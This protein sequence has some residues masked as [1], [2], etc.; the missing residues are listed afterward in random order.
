[1][2]GKNT[3]ARDDEMGHL[4]EELRALHVELAE[5]RKM[6]D[7]LHRQRMEM[8]VRQVAR[9]APVQPSR[10]SRTAQR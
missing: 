1:M 5:F 3:V 6:V 10:R 7:L 9:P 2:A 8:A 4:R